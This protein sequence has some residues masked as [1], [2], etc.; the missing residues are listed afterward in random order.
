MQLKVSSQRKPDVRTARTLGETTGWTSSD[1]KPRRQRRKTKA[2][3]GSQAR[4]KAWSLVDDL[5]ADD[6]GP[7]KGPRLDCRETAPRK[8]DGRIKSGYPAVPADSQESAHR[9]GMR[10][11][12]ARAID[13]PGAWSSGRISNWAK[14]EISTGPPLCVWLCH[15]YCTCSPVFPGIDSTLSPQGIPRRREMC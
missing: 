8:P 3:N 15:L 2:S 14:P 7:T 11:A 12:D 1:G 13:N 5:L 9:G 6:L 4:D 10:S